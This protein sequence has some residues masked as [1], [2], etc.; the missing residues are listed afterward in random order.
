MDGNIRWGVKVGVWADY[1]SDFNK[2]GQGYF[3][4]FARVRE[5]GT[6]GGD[7]IIAYRTTGWNGEVTPDLFGVE[8]I[9]KP[10]YLSLQVLDPGGISSRASGRATSLCG[11]LSSR[12]M[13]SG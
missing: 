4:I 3:L 12:F 8:D 2:A 1:P 11:I 7:K 13:T 9:S 5:E 6:E 10:W